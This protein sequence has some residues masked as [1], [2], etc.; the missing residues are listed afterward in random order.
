VENQELD[1]ELNVYIT[2]TNDGTIVLPFHKMK[3]ALF[4]NDGTETFQF[5]QCSGDTDIDLARVGEARPR[6]P[7]HVEASSSEISVYGPGRATLRATGYGSYVDVESIGKSCEI[8][9]QVR[10]AIGDVPVTLRQ[11]FSRMGQGE[12]REEYE[13]RATWRANLLPRPSGL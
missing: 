8:R 1:L 4:A 6:R 5:Q 7:A 13:W 2:P 3:A 9:F 12:T 10:T 11:H